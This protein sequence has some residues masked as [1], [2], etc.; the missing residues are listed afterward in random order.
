MDYYGVSIP[1][2]LQPSLIL[3]VET[4]ELGISAGLQDR[5]AQVYQGVVYM[6]FNRETLERQGYGVYEQIPASLLPS[7]YVAYR[8]DLSEGSEVVH[9]N[10][11]SRYLRGDAE[12]LDAIR[13]WASLASRVRDRL[14]AGQG[15][16]IGDLLDANF[17]RR[18]QVCQISAGNMKMVQTARAS[19]V[20]AKFTGS[21]GA[22]VGTCDG[23]S[24]YEALCTA[25]RAMGVEVVRPEIAPPTGED[26]R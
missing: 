7:L 25:M 6:D 18:A 1:K 16:Q 5:V 3:S 8:A 22:I 20:S 10:L 26:G 13:F 23:E 12:V 11:R 21:G 2:P 4:H 9:N 24:R 15:S 17:D 14:V 19:G